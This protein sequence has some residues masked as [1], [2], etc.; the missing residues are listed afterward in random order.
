MPTKNETLSRFEQSDCTLSPGEI[1]E[2]SGVYEICHADEPR[3]PVLLLKNT[4]FP[5]CRQCGN[6]VRYKLIQAAPHISEDPDLS[7]DFQETD[8]PLLRQ[9][10]PN[11]IVPLQLG[12]AHGFRFSQQTLQA[13]RTDP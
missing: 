9:I 2:Q 11:N 3:T 12:M 10:V 4:F 6:L 8:N 13:G 5:Y 1:V 7:E